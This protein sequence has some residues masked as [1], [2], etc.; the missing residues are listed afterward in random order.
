MIK[1]E[2]HQPES[3]KEAFGLMER[4]KGRAMYIAGGTD[5][6]VKIKHQAKCL[7]G[8]SFFTVDALISLR[9]IAALREIQY[10]GGLQLG[11]STPFR[12]IARASAV[13]QIYPALAEAVSVLA[14]PQ[15]RNVATVG[16]N[17]CN[18]SPC[19]DSVLALIVL[20]AMLTVEGPGGIRQVPISDFF[21]GP[22]QTVL[23]KVEI[24]TRI[25]IGKPRKGTVMKHLK[26][27][28]LTSDIAVVNTAA[29]LEMDGRKC[30]K[31]RLAAGSVAPTPLRLKKTEAI[32][33]GAEITPDLLKEVQQVASREVMPITDV[34]STEEYRRQ[35]AGVMVKRTISEALSNDSK[36]CAA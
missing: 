30:R 29:A 3:L 31:C 18:A 24:L 15:I 14:N 21:Q 17:I 13:A 11:A 12:S 4:C 9:G 25:D 16:G 10:N 2:Y 23:G 34:R 33:E 27:G 19:A 26:T 22:G 6:L 28:R 32:I 20:D 35:V 5:L 7:P 1:Y 36:V 8:E